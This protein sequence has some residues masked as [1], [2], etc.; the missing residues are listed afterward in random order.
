M[1]QEPLT[2]EKQRLAEQAAFFL[3]VPPAVLIHE[4]AHALA[5]VAFSGQVVEFG[6]RVFWGYVVPAGTFSAMQNWIIAVA[7]TIGSLAF[8][9]LMW[10]SLRHN[11][12]RTLRFFGLRAFRFQ[13]YF[14]LV[15]YPIFSLFLPIGDWR[16][17]YD[18]TATP[19][20]SGAFAAVHGL[21]LVLFWR[22]DRA[23]AF[24]MVAFDS[25]EAQS[26]YEATL[27]A[28]TAGDP[29]AR[30]QVIAN[31]WS[32]GAKHEANRQMAAYLKDQ[33]TSAAGYLQLAVM[34]GN[35]SQQISKSAYEAA[36]QAL[37]F[38]LPGA[39][40]VALARQIRSL[41][42]LERGQGAEA[43]AELDAVLTPTAVYD[44]EEIIPIRRAELH[45]LRSQA[46][47][48]QERYE[49]AYAEI[50]LALQ[51]ARQMALE[52]VIRRYADEKE[53]IE[54]HAGRSLSEPAQGTA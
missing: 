27:A 41:Y 19:I 11:P 33:P 22:G 49:A 30:L 18:F 8:G 37:A 15:Y 24:D 42:H 45:Y 4:L 7:G 36:G 50:E 51:L 48:R 28:A 5:V 23:G 31:L 2:R 47:R 35:G 12:S 16:V 54:K 38:G 53:L 3:G 29:G 32:G 21:L 46:Y 13:I 9:A 34:A 1:R 39:D 26:R 14:S 43:E 20:L 40:Q 6:Y 10:F 25:L 44:P 52:P 17:I